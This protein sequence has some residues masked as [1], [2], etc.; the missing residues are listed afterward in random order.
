M[1]SEKPR[2][3]R[4]GKQLAT[5]RFVHVTYETRKTLWSPGHNQFY[6]LAQENV[7]GL[8]ASRRS[9]P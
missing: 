2:F 4:F 1:I 9:S 6:L 5:L 7:N 3:L 8:D